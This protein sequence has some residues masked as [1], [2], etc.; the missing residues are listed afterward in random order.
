M[1]VTF[2]GIGVVVVGYAIYLSG[3]AAESSFGPATSILLNTAN[4]MY[5]FGVPALLIGAF[6]ALNAYMHYKSGAPT[7]RMGAPSSTES[8]RLLQAAQGPTLDVTCPDCGYILGPELGVR[9]PDGS[10]TCGRCYKRFIP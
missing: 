8:R 7:V 9:R 5:M 2:L 1:A 6:Y 10:V 3:R 4:T